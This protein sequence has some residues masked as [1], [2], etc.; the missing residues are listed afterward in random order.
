MSGRFPRSSGGGA[1]RVSREEFERLVERALENLPEEFAELLENVAVM[2]EEEPGPEDLEG[3]A[4]RTAE[5]GEEDE[6]EGELFGL[7]VG[8]PLTERDTFYQAMPDRVL[9]FRGPLLR[10]CRDRRELVEEITKTVLHELGHY[11]GMDEDQMPY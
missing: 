2:V 7:Y 4:T 11:F 3:L 10:A 5:E 1:L 6:E 9:I 8:V